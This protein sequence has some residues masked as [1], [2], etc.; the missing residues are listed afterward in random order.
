MSRIIGHLETFFGE[1]VGKD[2]DEGREQEQDY[3]CFG[4][5]CRTYS[6][7]SRNPFPAV[8]RHPLLD[9]FVLPNPKLVRDVGR[10]LVRKKA[11]PDDAVGF[12]VISK[13]KSRG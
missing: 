3:G 11:K 4:L 12:K 13:M 6:F 10:M 2:S 9:S 7:H 1:G 5:V 8:W